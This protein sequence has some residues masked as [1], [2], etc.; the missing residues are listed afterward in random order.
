MN[1]GLGAVRGTGM[2]IA[3]GVLA[4][5]LVSSCGYNEVIERDEDV[6]AGWAEVAG[7]VSGDDTIFIATADARAQARV[8]EQLR[9]AF[10]V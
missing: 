4:G 5:L 6:K 1:P 2:R 10:G 7:T 9:E 8:L 3:A